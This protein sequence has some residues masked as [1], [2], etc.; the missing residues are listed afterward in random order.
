[1]DQYPTSKVANSALLGLQEAL[2]SAR[3][4]DEFSTYLEKY[5]RA[6]PQD[7]STESIEFEAAKSLYLNEKYPQAIT[8]FENYVRTYPQSAQNYDA[9]YYIADAYYKFGDRPNAVRN[10]QQVIADGRSQYLLRSVSR[11][12][13]LELNAKKYASAAGYYRRLLTGSQSKKDQTAALAGLMESYYQ[14]PNYDSARY[15]ASQVAATGGSSPSLVN[16][17]LLYKGKSYYLQN[18]YEKALEELL[19]AANSAQDEYGAE[20]QYLVGESLY[21]QK[22]Y[23]ESL[24]MCF[25]LNDKFGA[26]EKWR[27][28]AFLLVADNYM[29]LEEPFQAKATLQSVIE[30]SDDKEIVEQAKAKLK[31]IQ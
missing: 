8:A 22:K 5:R 14:Q 9:R 4:S 15:F 23:K 3:R 20:A 12:A 27:G 16:K 31:T 10:F 1:L 25:A 7:N 17:A 24:E 28:R 6:N 18:N 26:F 13:D 21:K 29:A 19:S 30:N 2:A 11:M